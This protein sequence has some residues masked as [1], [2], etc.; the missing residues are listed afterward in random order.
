MTFRASSPSA[1]P[2]IILNNATSFPEE[3]DE[4]QSGKNMLFLMV[5]LGLWVLLLTLALVRLVIRKAREHRE[6]TGV[7]IF[8]RRSRR[9]LQA[10]QEAR[11]Q[12]HTEMQLRARPYGTASTGNRSHLSPEEVA[13]RARK[14]RDAYLG[15][16]KRNQVQLVSP[17]PTIHNQMMH[18]PVATFFA[19]SHQCSFTFLL[20]TLYS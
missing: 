19:V 10:Q 5:L 14:R 18:P 4:E 15:T 2:S 13:Q 1:A 3:E 8:D 12:I 6:A 9:R 7:S 20:S 16:F 11:R 17:A